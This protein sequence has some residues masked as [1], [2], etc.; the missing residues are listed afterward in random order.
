[1]EEGGNSSTGG[2][3]G[4]GGEDKMSQLGADL[5][6][7]QAKRPGLVIRLSTS[8]DL[9]IYSPTAGSFGQQIQ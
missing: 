1:M 6:K 5:P 8:V 2:E 4:D 7:Q 3:G 9:S